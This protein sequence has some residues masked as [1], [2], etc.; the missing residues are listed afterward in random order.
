MEAIMTANVVKLP[1][2]RAEKVKRPKGETAEIELFPVN[3]CPNRFVIERDI[4]R[5]A[6]MNRGAS[7]EN[8]VAY[9]SMDYLKLRVPP[10]ALRREMDCLRRYMTAK[11]NNI[12]RYTGFS[13]VKEAQRKA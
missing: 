10:D 5:I 13:E 9:L 4:L 2:R 12:R 1:K 6:A 3:R 11:T 7:I 8:T